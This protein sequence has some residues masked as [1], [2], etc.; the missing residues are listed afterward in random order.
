MNTQPVLTGYDK[1]LQ[2]NKNKHQR[3]PYQAFHCFCQGINHVA[4]IQFLRNI[5]VPTCTVYLG[6]D[7]DVK[8]YFT[9]RMR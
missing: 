7:K 9:R 4:M 6:V 5:S 1:E 3:Q 8:L 2:R